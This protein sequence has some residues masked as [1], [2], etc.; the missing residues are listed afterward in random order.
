MVAIVRSVDGFWNFL[1]SFWWLVFPLSAV[2]GGWAKGVQKWD[3]RRRRDKIELARIRYADRAAADEAAETLTADIDRTVATHDETLRRWLDYELDAAK[4][5]EFPLMTDMREPV[6]VDFHRARRDA[7]DLRPD[8]LDQL[9]DT[10]RFDRYREAVRELRTRFDVAESEA[11]RRRAS[12]LT[13]DERR[14]VDR[15]KK[16]LAVAED[17]GASTAERQSAYRRATKELEGIIVLPDAA[18]AAIEQR[19]AGA[20]DA[21]SPAPGAERDEGRGDTD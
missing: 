6:T 3:E 4:L 10:R 12:S 19:I 14:A 7:E 9:R 16:L 18:T 21:P 11:R 1:G 13:D 20:L 5:L 8:D 17:A 15:A 2:V